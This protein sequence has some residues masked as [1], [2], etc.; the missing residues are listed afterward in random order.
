[1]HTRACAH[2]RQVAAIKVFKATATDDPELDK[3]YLQVVQIE[4]QMTA[5]KAATEAH[6]ASLV[7]MCW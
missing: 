3:M 6:L 4:G 1:M 5:I 2:R 7:E